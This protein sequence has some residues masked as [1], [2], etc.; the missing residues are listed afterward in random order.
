MVVV[1][2]PALDGIL[3]DDTGKETPKASTPH[4][5]RV[6]GAIDTPETCTKSIAHKHTM[7]WPTRQQ[8][9]RNGSRMQPMLDGTATPRA[10]C[11][12]R[13]GPSTY[14]HDVGP[15]V[16]WGRGGQ[17]GRRAHVGWLLP[18]E[19]VPGLGGEVPA[20]GHGLVLEA[21][22]RLGSR[23]RGQ[24]LGRVRL[25][26]SGPALKGDVGPRGGGGAQGRLGR[27]LPPP[28]KRTTGKH[29]KNTQSW[30]W[31][32]PLPMSST[33]DRAITIVIAQQHASVSTRHPA[34]VTHLYW[35]LDSVL[36]SKG[37]VEGRYSYAGTAG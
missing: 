32:E 2:P 14:P 23:V 29:N 21:R 7:H 22:P 34:S 27:Q 36:P 35:S 17:Q 1:Q 16:G 10:R 5:K 9:T 6:S 31:S 13:R 12:P 15:L 26:G 8:N 3:E 33:H 11:A 24:C 30:W 19:R 28:V 4:K 25:G 20:V 18:S 37:T